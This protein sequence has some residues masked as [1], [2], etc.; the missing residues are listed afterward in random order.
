[1]K[2]IGVF[3]ASS[4]ALNPD[5]YVRAEELGFFLGS[6]DMALV[7][8]VAEMGLM[9]AVASGVRRAVPFSAANPR[10]IGVVPDILFEKGA[11][12][13]LPDRVMRCRDLTE[14]KAIMMRESDI[15][16]AM[17]GSVGT[18]DEAF[19]TMAQKVIGI[20]QKKVIFWNMDG[21]WN[22][23]FELFEK[24]KMTGVVNKPLEDLYM[25]ADSL[26][27]VEKFLLA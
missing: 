26:E 18:L 7:Y 20:A 17:P 3:C 14:R 2:K 9:E 23:L 25:R 10:V 11:V 22:G 1:M 16:V 19:S 21:F 15:L 5:F 4:E 27:E 24:M 12:S 13:S 6:H 8:A